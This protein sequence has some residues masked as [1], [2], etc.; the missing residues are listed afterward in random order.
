MHNSNLSTIKVVVIYVHTA[1]LVD[2]IYSEV[3]TNQRSKFLV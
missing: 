3:N 2:I 1:Y